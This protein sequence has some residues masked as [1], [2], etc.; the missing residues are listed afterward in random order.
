M[1]K[2]LLIISLFITLIFTSYSQVSINILGNSTDISGN[3]ATP[4]LINVDPNNAD[5]ILIG[6]PLDLEVK[7][8][9]NTD[10]VFSITRKRINVPSSWTEQFCSARGCFEPSKD[11]VWTTIAGQM[12]VNVVSGTSILLNLHYLPT[13]SDYGVSTFRYIVKDGPTNVDSVDVQINYTLGI[14]S[15]KSAPSFSMSP[16]PASESF[17][18]NANGNENLN[19]KIIDVLGNSVFNETVYSNKKIDVSD[20][21]N[22]VYFVTVESEDLKIT[23][24]KLVIRH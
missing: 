11:N 4:I 12:P 24:R 14:K 16:N 1:K 17:S 19:V 15:L 6:Y 10:K 3:S 22:G 20:F 23:N 2:T 7:N 9:Y 13:P 8:N 18:I 5:A 21:K